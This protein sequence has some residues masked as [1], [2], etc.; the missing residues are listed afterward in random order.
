MESPVVDELG[1]RGR[2]IDCLGLLL[3]L[4]LW[5]LPADISSYLEVIFEK[6]RQYLTLAVDIL[7][8]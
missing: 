6:I 1:E 8:T 2:F 7:P 3:F 5:L 4:L